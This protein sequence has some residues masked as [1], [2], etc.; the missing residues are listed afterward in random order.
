[1]R[2]VVHAFMTLDGVV[3]SP[4]SPEEDPSGGFVHG[5][6]ILPFV[7]RSG[8]GDVVDRW[9][10]RADRILLGHRTHDLMRDYWTEAGHRD[11]V[12]SAA[13][14][15]APKYV[16]SS[17]ATSSTWENTRVTRRCPVDL[18]T[19]LRDTPGGE[20]QV[21]GSWRV[22]WELQEADLVDEYRL[23]VFP[24]VLGSGKRVFPEGCPPVRFEEATSEWL[25]N[26]ITYR[27]L[28]V[29]GHGPVLPRRPET[30]G[31]SFLHEW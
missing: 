24:L 8:W 31:S 17:T 7:E 18:V 2:V 23:I 19:E 14:R 6:W 3:Q 20:L 22:V 29:A 26:G 11:N 1:M 13:L 15:A 9:F 21:H 10:E 25:D 12:A 4:G 30:G 5:G 27:R 16:L 28:G